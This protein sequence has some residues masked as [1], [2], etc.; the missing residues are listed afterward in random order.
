MIEQPNVTPRDPA[1]PTT[2]YASVVGLSTEAIR[3]YTSH[4]NPALFMSV[5]PH[6]LRIASARYSAGAPVADCLS[7]LGDAAQHQLRFIVEG[8]QYRFAGRGGIDNYL[9]LYSAAHLAGC[10]ATLIAALRQCV[11]AE[12]ERQTWLP[13]LIEQFCDVL[14]GLPVETDADQLSVLARVDPRVAVLPRLFVAVS[15]RDVPAAS[16]ALDD[17]LAQHWG[18][19]VEKQ[20]KRDLKSA[21]P[22]YCGKWCFLSAAMC[23]VLGVVPDLSPLARRYAPLDLLTEA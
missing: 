3:A 16:A 5:V 7:A 1:R 19:P 17:Y 21:Q 13:R 22:V 11:Y 23:R 9:E 20:A 12:P 6:F 14:L 8:R 10:S 2:Y 18:P 4:G 15:H